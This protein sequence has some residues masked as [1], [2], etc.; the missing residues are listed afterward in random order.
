MLLHLVDVSNFSEVGKGTP[1][2]YIIFFLSVLTIFSVEKKMG[3]EEKREK[4]EIFRN[5]VSSR[6]NTKNR[7][8]SK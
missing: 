2:I 4:K 3:R 8:C 5:L 6:R 7:F 1:Y